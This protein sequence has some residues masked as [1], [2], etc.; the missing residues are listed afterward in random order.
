MVLVNEVINIQPRPAIIIMLTGCLRIFLSIP[1]LTVSKIKSRKMPNMTGSVGMAAPIL[2]WPKARPGIEV[3]FID[4]GVKKTTPSISLSSS[5]SAAYT[6]SKTNG[7]A[8]SRKLPFSRI[9]HISAAIKAM[10]KM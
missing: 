7:S 3:K 9:S 6:T 4:S 1:C 10:L 2:I 8:S 5:N